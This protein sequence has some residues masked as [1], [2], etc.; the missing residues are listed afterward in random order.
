MV[1]KVDKSEEFVKSG[2]DLISEYHS[3]KE[4]DLEI[5]Q[6]SKKLGKKQEKQPD[7]LDKNKKTSTISIEGKSNAEIKT[8]YDNAKNNIEKNKIAM[9]LRKKIQAMPQ[10]EQIDINAEVK[11]ILEG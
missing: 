10:S 9:A 4:K 2:K 3:K 5:W 11:K 7:P 1:V 8:M 6:Y